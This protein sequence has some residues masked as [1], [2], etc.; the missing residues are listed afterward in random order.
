MPRCDPVHGIGVVGDLDAPTR[1]LMPKSYRARSGAQR[2]R[3]Q[4][5]E[6]L[7]E[8]ARGRH[9]RLPEPLPAR[10]VESGEDLATAR[11][12]HGEAGAIGAGELLQRPA[13]GIERAD[14]G[15]GKA[16][17][18]RQAARRGDGYPHACEGARP[19]P[20]CDP[21]DGLPA[22]GGRGG[23]LDLRQQRGRV[24]RAAVGRRP[25]QL[26]VQRLAAARRADGGVGG[27]RV[28]A[29]DRQLASGRLSQRR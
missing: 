16:C 18:G 21:V 6:A 1:Q 23:P 26:L 12:E 22:T 3:R 14:A 24:A 20:D 27:R 19:A 9:E 8:V 7:G 17:A 10:R 25:E 5:G 4:L 2:W 15:N 13:E 28:E 29:D 11:V